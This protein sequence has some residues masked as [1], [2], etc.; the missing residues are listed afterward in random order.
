MTSYQLTPKGA[1]RGAVIDIE[2]TIQQRTTIEE[3][4]EQEQATVK[5]DTHIIIDVLGGSVM[6]EPE[7]RSLPDALGDINS[8]LDMADHERREL[9]PLEGGVII[10]A[11]RSILLLLGYASQK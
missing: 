8:M 11:A 3:L 4:N 10:H 5:E 2:E 1:I 6:L 9:N 7:S